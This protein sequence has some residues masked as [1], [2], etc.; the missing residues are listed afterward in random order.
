M[1]DQVNKSAEEQAQLRK[2][3][4]RSNSPPGHG[5]GDRN[6]M[7]KSNPNTGKKPNKDGIIEGTGGGD[8]Q[9]VAD[10]VVRPGPNTRPYQK[11]N[12]I[13]GLGGA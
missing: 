8:D 1:V 9:Q 13:S 10:A 3:A 6:V 5:T 7:D 2:Q 11:S 12:D 4:L